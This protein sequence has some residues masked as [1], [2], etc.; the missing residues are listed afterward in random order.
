[1]P[2]SQPDSSSLEDSSDESSDVTSFDDDMDRGHDDDTGADRAQPVDQLRLLEQRQAAE[3]RSADA[4]RARRKT[5]Y[6]NLLARVACKGLAEL[7]FHYLARHYSNTLFDRR[8]ASARLQGQRR[9][10]QHMEPGDIHATIMPQLDDDLAA[11][12]DR[13][14]QSLGNMYDRGIPINDEN[15]LDQVGRIGDPP[16]HLA[17][18][19]VAM[20]ARRHLRDH[21][22]APAADL[23]APFM[24]DQTCD[25]LYY[26]SLYVV[27]PMLGEHGRRELQQ[28]FHDYSLSSEPAPETEQASG[29]SDPPRSAPPPF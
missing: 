26:P 13:D 21:M 28:W 14:Y 5:A 10:M 20:L 17:L 23:I 18:Q 7:C 15:W 24:V 9:R 11:K 27:L 16:R 3:R 29:S 8:T 25:M 1:M 19:Q 6:N 22:E 2:R 4:E 12:L